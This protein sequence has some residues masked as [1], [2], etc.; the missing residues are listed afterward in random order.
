MTRTPRHTPKQWIGAWACGLALL[1]GGAAQAADVSIQPAAGDA[2][3]VRGSAGEQLRVQEDG[4]QT[5]LGNF[6]DRKLMLDS[7]GRVVLGPGFRINRYP[8]EVQG[9]TGSFFDSGLRIQNISVGKGWSFYPASS[10]DMILGDNSNAAVIDPV[11]GAYSASSDER[12]KTAIRP[13]EGVLGKV[14]NL[15]LSRYRYKQATT[16]SLGVVA[17]DLQQQFPEFVKVNTTDEGKPI[18]PQQMFVDYAGLSVVA[19]RALQ[20]QQAQIQALQAELQTLK[21]QV[22]AAR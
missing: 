14:L 13:L 11:T 19:L 18:A 2:F 3:V 1:L 9:P 7:Q 17:Q 5:T 21:A 15:P 4:S 12:A 8:F 16:D 20:E 6:A 22:G 10:G